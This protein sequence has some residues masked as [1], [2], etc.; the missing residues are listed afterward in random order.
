MQ[1]RVICWRPRQATMGRSCRSTGRSTTA[2][3]PREASTAPQECG[4]STVRH[5][6]GHP[7]ECRRSGRRWWGVS[8]S[9]DGNRLAVGDFAVAST[10]IFDVSDVGEG[11]SSTSGPNRGREGR[12]PATE[13][14]PSGRTGSSGQPTCR[15]A[16]EL[17][18]WTS[19]GRRHQ[20]AHRGRP[21]RDADRRAALRRVVAGWGRRRG[22]HP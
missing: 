14:S 3:S 1:R 21:V 13:S 10:K 18:R 4:V 17:R 9:P 16:A 2:G 5:C 11:S 8:F 22:A 6:G 20:R 19:R 15:P 7:A 12:S